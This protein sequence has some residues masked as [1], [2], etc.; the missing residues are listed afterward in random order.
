LPGVGTIIGSSSN[1]IQHTSITI[2][3]TSGGFN[4]DLNAIKSDISTFNN[5][6]SAFLRIGLA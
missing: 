4:M 5:A 6:S 3:N 2:V 1:R